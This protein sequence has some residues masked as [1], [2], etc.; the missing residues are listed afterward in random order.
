VL[1]D[2]LGTLTPVAEV[3][4][5]IRSGAPGRDETEH[6]RVDRN[7]TELLGEL[8]V[9]LPGVQVLFAFLLTVPF[10]QRFSTA[11]T[12]EKDIYFVTLCSTA[13]ASILLIAPSA[14]HRIEFRLQDKEHIVDVAN[15]FAIVGF[16]FLGLGMTGAILLV[17]NFL[18]S[19]VTA[20]IATS[21][22]GSLVAMAWYALP[23]RRRIRLRRRGRD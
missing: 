2:P 16:A 19:T 15:R 6:E 22:A 14:Y 20:I 13:V 23:L 9:A 1:L 12:F 17:T 11:S 21:I 10:Q 8:R 18:F 4:E 7:L 5:R 3:E